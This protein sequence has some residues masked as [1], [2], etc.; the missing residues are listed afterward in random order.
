MLHQAC[1][2]PREVSQAVP[3]RDSFDRAALGGDYWSNGGS[4]R[5]ADGHLYS[6]GV[7][8]NPLWL[9]ARLP[10][11]A[12]IS[13]DA[14]SDGPSGDIQVEAWGDGRN[15]GSGY[16]FILGDSRTNESR[17]AKSDERAPTIEELRAQLAARARPLP[18]RA[19]G[20]A[21]VWDSVTAPFV[22]WAAQRD[23]DRLAAGTYFETDT[24]LA[25]RRSEA[26]V[27]RG[28]HYHWVISKKG[29]SLR[30]EVDGKVVLQMAD[31]APLTGSEGV[32]RAGHDRF[33]FSSWQT[34][35]N[36]D[37]LQID[38]IAEL[39]SNP[40][41]P[42][43]SAAAVQPIGPLGFTERFDRAE[44]GSDWLNTGAPY[45]VERGHLSFQSA[46]N[47]PLW[48]NRVL[49]REVRVEFDCT[50]LSADAD[51]KVELFG[52]GRSYES[53]E[54]VQRDAQYTATGYV[55]ILGGWKNKVSTIVKQQEHAWQHDRTVPRSTDFRVELGRSY[56]WTIT[57]AGARIEWKLDGKAFLAWD[58]PTPLEGPGHDHFAFT[59]WESP[60]ACENLKIDP[61]PASAAHR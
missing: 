16:I 58:D 22:K 4:W 6:P 41:S 50:A 59:G 10:D 42:A 33:G 2:G 26:A 1:R 5:L 11:D 17:I 44:L 21:G 3:F 37:N 27:V 40:A 56:H 60:V 28:Q 29:G 31:P 53:A 43:L 46:H 49:P 14:W 12:R 51:V 25:V 34:D 54:D 19:T 61:L 48:L 23:L 52:D 38:P 8:H 35:T 24:P 45:R 13:F 30:W 20:V 32:L 18:V 39:D 36:F 57:R 9:K 55:F 47:H 15:H 7:G